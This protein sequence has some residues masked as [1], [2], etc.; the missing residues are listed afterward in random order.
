MAHASSLGAE[1]HQPGWNQP[2]SAMHTPGKWLF[3]KV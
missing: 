1:P 3:L 2:S